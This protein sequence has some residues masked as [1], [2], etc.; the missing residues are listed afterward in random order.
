MSFLI[1]YILRKIFVKLEFSENTIALQKGFFIK[2]IFVVP[3]NSVVKI[4]VERTPL[5]RIFRA[6]EVKISTLRGGIKFYLQKDEQ[7]PFL[8][9][10]Q[11][12][13]LKTCFWEQAFGAFIA[14]R[15]LAGVVIFAALLRRIGSVFGSGYY[16]KIFSALFSAAENLTRLLSFLHIAVPR[17]AAAIAVFALSCWILSFVRKLL[18][19]ARFRV[20]RRGEY[21]TVA[22]GLITLYEHTLVLNSA[23]AVSVSSVAS[24]IADRAPIYVRGV[25]IH[26]AVHRKNYR[27]TLKVLC[28]I[29]REK[30]DKAA[31][32][33]RA[34]FG[35][36]AAPLCWSA[37]FAALIMLLRF[38]EYFRYAVLLKTILYVSLA[39]SLYTAFIYFLYMRHSGI[40][41]GERFSVI[42][43]RSKM[44]LYTA[45]FPNNT[46]LQSKI[47][48]S[49][50][51]RRSRLCSYKIYTM[52]RQAFK[53]RSVP[54]EKLRQPFAVALETTD[55]CW[56]P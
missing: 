35:Y 26:P 50:F 29:T 27:K 56:I 47:T 31:P 19:L 49:L 41:Y 37:L 10:R 14:T 4:S 43:S 54:K 28:N 5:L 3:I 7:L 16:N 45:V 36:C 13:M 32:P 55:I 48:Q 51:Q 39:V 34:F 33:L 25:M 6:K 9:T 15:A 38:S 18:T 21:L 1:Y 46:V 11:A 22:G 8:P 42:A 23:A 52:E 53:A 40:A 20:G 2:R 12:P 17:I 24:L 44:R 30:T